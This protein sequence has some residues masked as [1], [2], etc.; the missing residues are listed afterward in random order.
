MIWIR[1]ITL[2]ILA[3]A[4][5]AVTVAFFKHNIWPW[6]EVH[7]GTV[8][9]SGPYYGFWSGFGSDIGEATLIAGVFAAYHHHNCH[10]KGCPFLGHPVDG[11]P[12]VACPKHHPA[13]EGEK[14]GVSAKTIEE[15]FH[16][17]K[18]EKA[19]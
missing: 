16:R 17:S 5:I 18:K 2:F 4:V 8:N 13:H 1:R 3:V 19:A 7:T 14:R 10:V 9:E 11:T 15:H 6:L 12:Y